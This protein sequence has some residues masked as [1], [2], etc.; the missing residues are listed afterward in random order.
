MGDLNERPDGPVYQ[1]LKKAGYVDAAALG[2]EAL[3][4]YGRVRI[5]YVWIHEEANI[6]LR[7]YQVCDQPELSN[8]L[9]ES[10]SSVSDHSPV[11]ASLTWK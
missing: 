10:F 8:S 2:K 4:T 5:D 1:Q 11:K 9:S 7:D 6:E 3:S